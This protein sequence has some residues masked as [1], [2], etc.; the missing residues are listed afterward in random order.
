MFKLRFRESQIERWAARNEDDGSDSFASEVGPAARSRGHLT[1]EEFCAICAWKSPRSK[2]LCASN[3]EELVQEATAMAFSAKS[4]ELRIGALLVLRGVNWPTASVF[5][6]FC[7]SDPYPV[8][9]F[10]ALW[11]LKAE[12]PSVYNFTFWWGYVEAC[13]DLASRNRVSMRT[14]DRALWQYSKERQPA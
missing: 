12:Q 2:P 3:S 6:H 8:L 1:R 7:S 5:L 4:E 13:R 11:S 9:D 14:L 10:R